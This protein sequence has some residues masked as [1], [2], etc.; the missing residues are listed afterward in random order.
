MV[1]GPCPLQGARN[2]G[3][4]VERL[5]KTGSHGPRLRLVHCMPEKHVLGQ[6]TPQQALIKFS[7]SS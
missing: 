4:A 3:L 7:G 2:S 1:P 6:P 5:T